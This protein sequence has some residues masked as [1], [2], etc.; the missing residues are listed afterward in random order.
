[1]SRKFWIASGAALL[2]I[3]TTGCQ[4]KVGGQ[5]VAVVDGNEITQ[6]EL[7]GDLTSVPVP[8]T[9]DKK[10][11]LSDVLQGIINRKILVDQAKA[12]GIDK[13]PEYLTS[14]NK[15]KDALMIKLLQN[16]IAKTIPVPD[17]SAVKK[18]VDDNPSLF[19]ARKRYV[20]DQ[21]YF[22]ASA[23]PKALHD[24]EPAHS[25]DAIAKVLASYNI[26]FKRGQGQLD[27]GGVPPEVFKKIADLPP[28]EPFVL[29][30]QGS[31]VASVIT[32][33]V[34]I[35][36]PTDQSNAMAVNLLRQKA[37][38]DAM[39]ARLEASKKSAK[40]EVQPNLGAN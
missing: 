16:K 23:N 14:L 19:A 2:V 36:T 29:P 35:P 22:P 31:L 13:T 15:E 32:S 20:L 5:V 12:D 3:V 39:K 18:F 11:V 33:S 7:N 38:Q 21:I 25:L 28:G 9:A 27:S 6:Q 30:N 10:K 17:Q 24:L 8:A 40:I 4:K 26:P 37:V 34:A 1:V